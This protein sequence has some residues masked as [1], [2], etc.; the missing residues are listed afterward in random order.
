MPD[1]G[2]Q[3]RFQEAMSAAVEFA[4][5]PNGWLVFTGPSGSGKTHLAVAVTNR[6]IELG[7]TAF[8]IVV[9]DLLD[10]LRATYGPDSPVT[11]DQLFEQ[12]RNVPLLVID[13]L[14]AA[15]STPWA[16]EK[17]F[18]IVNHRFNAQ[19]PT[20]IT[21]RG[22][23]ERLDEALRTRIETAN[24][25]SRVFQLGEYN[26][27][28][29]RSIGNIPDE[30]L[31]GMT[32]AKFDT[33]GA[34]ETTPEQQGYLTNAYRQAMMFASYPNGWIMFSG[35]PG[36]G[37]THLAVAIA[38]ELR[39]RGESVLFAPVL[40][41]LDHLKST[42][43]PN[44]LVT[45]DEL[46]EQIKTVPVLILDDLGYLSIDSWDGEK[47]YQIVAYR[48]EKSLPTIITT[49]LPFSELEFSNSKLASRLRD[50]VV[51]EWIGIDAPDFRRD[52]RPD[53]P[54]DR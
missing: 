31:R 36:S 9:A 27:R 32:F 6:C 1:A 50:T 53:L 26:T 30:M 10:H 54:P 22:Q 16:Q 18:Q 42:V 20:I 12:V 44:S 17:L 34:N 37:K 49:D 7:R 4:E 19:L 25:F 23:T 21:V 38:G 33:R 5:D 47:L 40:E 35:P 28:L 48:H 24:G 11:Y 29:A 15:I 39:Q 14:S 2:S 3:Q 45:Y 51:V 46:F 8:F 43:R 41:L 52:R 13:D